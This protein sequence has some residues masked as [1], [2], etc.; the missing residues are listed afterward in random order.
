MVKNFPKSG[1]QNRPRTAV[2]G[3]RYRCAMCHKRSPK[4]VK[5]AAPWYCP[6]CQALRSVEAGGSETASSNRLSSR[7]W[8]L[9]NSTRKIWSVKI[10][11]SESPSS[12]T[13]LPAGNE[14]P[15]DNAAQIPSTLVAPKSFSASKP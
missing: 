6:K 3:K 7:S 15:L 11:F 2:K 9:Q 13:D 14:S 4:P 10:P 5:A 8:I 12:T 1:K